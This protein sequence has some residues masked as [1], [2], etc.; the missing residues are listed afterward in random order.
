MTSKEFLKAK[1]TLGL[2][3]H[4]LAKLLGYRR[5]TTIYEIT[6]GARKVAPL[7]ENFLTVLLALGET[8]RKLVVGHILGGNKGK[9]NLTHS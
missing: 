8:N 3:N 7:I 9:L 4:G 6:S 2:D 1:A 5:V